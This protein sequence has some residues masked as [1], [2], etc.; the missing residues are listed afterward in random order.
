MNRAY[1]FDSNT[2]ENLGF[3]PANKNKSYTDETSHE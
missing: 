2:D 1:Y 3:H